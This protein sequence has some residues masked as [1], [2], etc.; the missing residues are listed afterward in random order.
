MNNLEMWLLS[1][2]RETV[3]EHISRNGCPSCPA[4][5]YCKSSALRC[6]KQIL[7]AWEKEGA[8]SA[9]NKN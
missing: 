1:I 5:D 3:I 9:K 8:E 6:C 2:P 4:Q 7:A